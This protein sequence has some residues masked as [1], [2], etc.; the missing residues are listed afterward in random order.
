LGVSAGFPRLADIDPWTSCTNAILRAE[1]P[2]NTLKILIY[3][4][5]PF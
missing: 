5:G 3:A 1:I 4:R 2:I